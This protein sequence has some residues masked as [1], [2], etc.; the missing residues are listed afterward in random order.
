MIKIFGEAF[1]LGIP[2]G[3]FC[4]GWCSP[5]LISL[6]FSDNSSFKKSLRVI[7]EFISGR[8]IAYIVFGGLLGYLGNK[9]SNDKIQIFTSISIIVL[10]ILLLSNG[11]FRIFTNHKLCKLFIKSFIFKRFPLISGIL[12]GFNICPPFL[13]AIANVISVGDPIK[14]IFFFFSF[15]VG[16]SLYLI[17]F[18][19][20]ASLSRFVSLRLVAQLSAIISGALFFLIG[21]EKLIFFFI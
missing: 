17:P 2:T 5:P 12:I 6:I 1:L 7:L 8:L 11:I 13:I 4:L 10:S 18:I 3:I 9:L 14:G 16:T 20:S 19:F 21:F 15:F